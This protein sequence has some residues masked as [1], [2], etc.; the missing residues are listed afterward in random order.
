M[1]IRRDIV[2]NYYRNLKITLP[3]TEKLIRFCKTVKIISSRL[4]HIYTAEIKCFLDFISSIKAKSEV[5]NQAHFKCA[6]MSS[7]VA[8][9]LFANLL[10]NCVSYLNTW[11]E[12]SRVIELK[13]YALW[14]LK[15]FM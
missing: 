11:L 7:N 14:M 3:R 15:K 4:L 1:R 12:Q 13:I 2:F 8:L 6:A 9:L 5:Y 10:L